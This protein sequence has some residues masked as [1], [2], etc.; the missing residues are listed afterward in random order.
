MQNEIKDNTASISY[1]AVK[2]EV[3]KFKFDKQTNQW[4]PVNLEGRNVKRDKPS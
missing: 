2:T 1:K 3:I 4:L